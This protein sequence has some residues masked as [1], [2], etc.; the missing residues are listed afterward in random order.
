[1][2]LAT[3]PVIYLPAADFCL[4]KNPQANLLSPAD[5]TSRCLGPDS[6][7]WVCSKFLHFTV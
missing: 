3:T 6:P 5:L 7:Y 1:L 4:Q 2:S